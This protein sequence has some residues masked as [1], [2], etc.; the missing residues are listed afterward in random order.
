MAQQW[1]LSLGV[2]NTI[3]IVNIDRRELVTATLVLSC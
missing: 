2:L 3:F 1:Y